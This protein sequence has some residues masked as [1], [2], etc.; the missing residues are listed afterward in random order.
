[1]EVLTGNSG[2]LE[3]T[4]DVD[5]ALPALLSDVVS[6][7]IFKGD[8]VSLLSCLVERSS[9]CQGSILDSCL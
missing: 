9:S 3:A 6:L 5:W 7:A 2:T 8:K 1:M 4:E